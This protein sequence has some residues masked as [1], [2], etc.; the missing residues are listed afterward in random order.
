MERVVDGLGG[1]RAVGH[2]LPLRQ[3]PLLQRVSDPSRAPLAQLPPYIGFE[4]EHFALEVIEGAVERQRLLGDGAAVVD[5]Q[6][7]ELAPGVRHTAS[8]GHAELE[9]G[10]VAAEVVDDEAAL[11]RRSITLA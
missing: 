3:Q 10:L 1:G 8:L 4:I 5:P 9:A 11:P 2:L 6:L 7:V